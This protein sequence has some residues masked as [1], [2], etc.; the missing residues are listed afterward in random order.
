MN[1]HP[2]NHIEKTRWGDQIV[3]FDLPLMGEEM[4]REETLEFNRIQ[5]AKIKEQGVQKIQTSLLDREEYTKE[6]VL[7]R[8]EHNLED[9]DVKEWDDTELLN[10]LPF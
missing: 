2:F 10:D 1:N 3:E 9:A 7:K 8:E 4:N 6:R 5:R